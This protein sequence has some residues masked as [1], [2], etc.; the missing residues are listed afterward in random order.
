M[1]VTGSWFIWSSSSE[2]GAVISCSCR[3]LAHVIKT[4]VEELK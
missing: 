4:H 1:V 2:L 3:E